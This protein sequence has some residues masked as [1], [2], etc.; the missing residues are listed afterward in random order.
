VSP[1]PI[2]A[3][4]IKTCLLLGFLQQHFGR[5]C[6]PFRDVLPL[7]GLAQ[8]LGQLLELAQALGTVVF[9]HLFPTL[10]VMPGEVKGFAVA[11][12]RFRSFFAHAVDLDG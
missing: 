11:F 2:L 1:S 6:F 10:R 9:P 7:L 3:D 5:L 12:L 8:A 4:N